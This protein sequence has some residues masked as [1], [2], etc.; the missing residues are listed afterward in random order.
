MEIKITVHP[1]IGPRK[2]YTGNHR[3][4]ITTQQTSIVIVIDEQTFEKIVKFGDRDRSATAIAEKTLN[5]NSLPVSVRELAELLV[6]DCRRCAE[7]YAGSP[8]RG[9]RRFTVMS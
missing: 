9:Y 8:L 1:E 3:M 7:L 4:L 2:T 6:K 5:T